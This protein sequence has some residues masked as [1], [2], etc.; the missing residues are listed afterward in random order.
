MT[1]IDEL[2]GLSKAVSD[3]LWEMTDDGPGR[4]HLI[5]PE[6]RDKRI[7]VSEQESKIIFTKVLDQSHWFYSVETPTV[8]T[9][10]QSG[11]TPLSAR[12]DISLY[13]TSSPSS[14]LVNIELKAHNTTKEN[15]RKDLEKLLREEIDGLWFHTLENC[16]SA[17]LPRIC[18]KFM[19]A[20]YDLRQ[21]FGGKPRI[22][23]VVFCVLET[24]ELINKLIHI[25]GSEKEVWE[26][27]Q[28]IFSEQSEIKYTRKS[29]HL[30][31]SK[32]PS[33]S[34]SISWPKHRFIFCK[35]LNSG[36][37]LLVTVRGN[38]YKLRSLDND[39][40][41]NGFKQSDASTLKELVDKYNFSIIT[42][43]SSEDRSY[44]VQRNP[45]Y[46][47]ERIKVLNEKLR[48]ARPG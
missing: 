21:Y 45:D 12:T 19:D 1:F 7:R 20:F 5:F 27:I 33:Y 37:F 15:L 10:V 24:K 41:L 29:S 30:S 39:T 4:P 38:S 17:T 43:I 47:Q 44:S 31:K 14:K 23:L 34:G 35:E 2:K 32:K 9:Y 18:K 3:K 28:K 16:N 36:S 42:E 46:W 13:E 40:W 48:D 8:Q 25:T 11:A 6:Y 22:I 26:T